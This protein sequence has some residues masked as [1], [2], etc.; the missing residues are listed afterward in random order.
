MAPPPFMIWR[1]WWGNEPPFLVTVLVL[2]H[3]GRPPIEFPNGTR[4][5]FRPITP[6]EALE[7]AR[8]LAGDR[9]IRVGGGASVVREFLK[10]GLIDRLHVALTPIVLGRGIR[11][12]GELLPLE[13]DF[14]VTSEVAE[15]G[16]IQVT[17]SRR[18]QGRTGRVSL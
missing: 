15:S 13:R 16:V 1:G 12:W 14:V 8:G 11:L 2:T 9:D 3:T 4:F 7:E 6:V 10:V 18:A 17:F 5:E